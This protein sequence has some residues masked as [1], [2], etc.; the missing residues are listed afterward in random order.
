MYEVWKY[1]I[2]NGNVFFFLSYICDKEGAHRKKDKIYELNDRWN[3]KY[4]DAIHF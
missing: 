2:Q 4:W 1:D 3:D